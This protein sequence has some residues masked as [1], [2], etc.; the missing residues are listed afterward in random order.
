MTTT[1]DRDELLIT[2]AT[3]YYELDQSQQQ[4]ANRLQISRSSVSRLIAEAR[5]HG[6]VTIQIHKSSHRDF[7][8]E[9]ELIENFGLLDAY[10]LTSSPHLDETTSLDALGTMA[11]SYLQRIIGSLEQHSTIGVAWGTSVQA[12]VQA[13]PNQFRQDLDVVQLLG[14]VGT[15][16]VDSPDLARMVAAKL[17]G[18]HYDLP[19]PA[20]VAQPAIRDVLLSEPTVSEAI[21]R[22]CGVGLAITGVGTTQEETSSFLR[23]GLISQT[24]LGVLRESGA[25]GEM[26]GRFFDID[27]CDQTFDINQRVVGIE[28]EDLRKIPQVLA[29]AR[30]I[31]KVQSILGALRGHFMNVLATDDITARAILSLV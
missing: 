26:C 13:I 20:L 22:A 16:V 23:A 2:V 3:L 5:Q 9:Q 17:G 6:I 21:A 24:E 12:A 1:M 25:V 4:I 19:A 30:G 18:R 7:A 29:V 27:G 8:L 15:L 11:T 31:A 28:L 10:V 14:G